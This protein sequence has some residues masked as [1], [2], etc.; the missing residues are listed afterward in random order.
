MN[1]NWDWDDAEDGCEF[2]ECS[3]PPA[4]LDAQLIILRIPR[5]ST[6]HDVG[7][8]GAVDVDGFVGD[9]RRRRLGREEGVAVGVDGDSLVLMLAE[10]LAGELSA[11][12]WIFRLAVVCKCESV[13]GG[14]A[15]RRGNDKTFEEVLLSIEPDR[16]VF[17]NVLN[18]RFAAIVP[19]C[20]RSG[21][22]DTGEGR[23]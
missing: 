10:A 7:V 3:D 22:T 16:R 6:S 23:I 4:R 13:S 8:A 5:N 9:R 19:G 20:G 2:E 12:R 14:G 15:F 21:D 17:C 11:D 1:R 18:E